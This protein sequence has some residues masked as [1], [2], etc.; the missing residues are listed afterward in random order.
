MEQRQGITAASGPKLLTR[1]FAVSCLGWAPTMGLCGVIHVPRCREVRRQPGFVAPRSGP[2]SQGHKWWCA[3]LASPQNTNT[4]LFSRTCEAWN[5]IYRGEGGKRVMSPRALKRGDW[6]NATRP[7][8]VSLVARAWLIIWGTMT[9]KSVCLCFAFV[10]LRNPFCSS[11][12]WLVLPIS[13]AS[14]ANF[15]S[16]KTSGWFYRGERCHWNV[17]L[18]QRV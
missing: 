14:C 8:C 11:F 17:L 18:D 10:E 3:N 5:T 7:F 6:A 1:Q 15:Y 13:V 4:G 2:R 12:L 16:N 9:W